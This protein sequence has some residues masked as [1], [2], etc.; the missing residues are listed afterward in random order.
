MQGSCIPASI[1]PPPPINTHRSSPSGQKVSA[2]QTDFSAADALGPSSA[3][4]PELP[5]ECEAAHRVSSTVSV[6]VGV[7][8]TPLDLFASRESLGNEVSAS[9]DGGGLVLMDTDAPPALRRLRPL[10][11]DLR[12]QRSRPI[13][14]SH[15][16]TI[17]EALRGNN[18]DHQGTGV[19]VR[20][21]PEGNKN[22]N[23]NGVE[24]DDGNRDRDSMLRSIRNSGQSKL[25]KAVSS[26]GG[27]DPRTSLGMLGGSAVS[28][29]LARRKHFEESS[30]WA[31]SDE[32]SETDVSDW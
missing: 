18:T 2:D 1:P 14:V 3:E 31:G 27:S 7:S 29:I 4:C 15:S 10:S 21:C 16:S 32:D 8:A 5:V 13:S 25:K 22:R 28:A 17:I 6:S 20:V 23:I 11:V 24:D 26:P 12:R 30:K 19:A 9:G